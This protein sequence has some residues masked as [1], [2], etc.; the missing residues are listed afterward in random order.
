M[1]TPARA[2]PHNGLPMLD[3]YLSELRRFRNSAAIYGVATLLILVLLGQLVDIATAP[4]E[5]HQVMLLLYMLSGLGFAAY[6]FGTYRQPSRWIWLQHRPLHRARILAAIAL[7][8]MT[9]IALAMAVPL[10]VVLFAQDVFTHRVIDQ[11]HYAGAAF[12]ALSALSAWLAGAYI[13]L[14]R[15]RWAFVILVLPILLTMHLAPYGTVLALSLLC[16]AVLLALVHTV[17]R[18][19]RYTASDAAATIATAVPLQAS[20]YLALL[21]AGSTLFQVGQMLAGVH[22]LSSDHFARGGYVEAVRFDAR[23]AMLAGLAGASD[24]R[25]SGWKAALDR[26]NTANVGPDLRQFAVRDGLTTVGAIMFHD[27]EQNA[28][29]FSHDRMMYSGLNQRTHAYRGWYGSAGLGDT[30]A[31]DSQP[32]PLRDNRGVG[33]LVNAHDMYELQGPALQLR[34][35]LHV[36]GAEQ[37]GGGVAV[38]GRRTALLTNRRLVIMEAGAAQPSVV[39]SMPLPLPFGDLERADVAQVADGTLVSFVYGHRR[40]DGVPGAPQLTYLVDG[41]GKVREVARRELAH[42]FPVLFEHKDWWL[43]PVLHALVKL[44]AILVDNGTVPDDGASRFEPLTRARPGSVWAA[45][46]VAALGSAIGAAW[47]MRR[48]RMSP[49]AR[50]AWCVV[51]LLLGCPALLSLMV[52]RPG[53]QAVAARTARAAPPAAA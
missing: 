9:L 38:L 10:F 23:E 13:V 2:A 51:C 53:E 14:H 6:Q 21:W 42:D 47:W 28:W 1:A 24:P 35:L 5:L 15:S 25:A 52:L 11:R 12:L 33:Y 19:D 37:F 34:H 36:D 48:A 40:L 46:I 50:A 7:A 27:H 49:R 17:F 39:A 8:S 18:P 32:V 16:N 44:P 41:T 31:F 4:R 29:T 30:G 22:P 20:F 45:A 43:S 3:L 26:K